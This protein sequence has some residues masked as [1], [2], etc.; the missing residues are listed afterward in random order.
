M[1]VFQFYAAATAIWTGTQGLV[2]LVSPTLISTLLKSVP[3][4]PTALES[5]LCAALGI[6]VMAIGML[7]VL[8]TGSIPLTSSMRSASATNRQDEESGRKG[9]PYNVPSLVITLVYHTT[10]S[11][12]MYSPQ[13][14]FMSNLLVSRKKSYKCVKNKFY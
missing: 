2:L 4:S 6:S 14:K 10:M 9:S 3:S 5:Y 12:L 8:L 7:S 1:D 13:W 11:F